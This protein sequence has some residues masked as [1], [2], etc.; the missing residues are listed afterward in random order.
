MSVSTFLQDEFARR[1]ARNAGYSL[2]AFARALEID[3]S[4][5]SQMMRGQRAVSVRTLEQFARRLGVAKSEL[6]RRCE[7]ERFDRK[8]LGAIAAG[9]HRSS[10]ELAAATGAD[11]DQ[12]NIALHR[13]LRL[14]L[15]AMQGAVWLVSKEARA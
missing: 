3:H 6:K 11:V 15:L 2:R 9:A 4:T 13:L 12:V 5:R 10:H 14:G 7:I 8:V 1:R